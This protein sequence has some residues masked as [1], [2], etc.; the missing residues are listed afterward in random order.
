M[1]ARY[2]THISRLV[3]I[4][5]LFFILSESV[6]AIDLDYIVTIDNPNS[7]QAKVRMEVKNISTEV[8][9]V[10]EYGSVLGYGINVINLIAGDKEGNPLKVDYL[11]SN[12]IGREPG[13][14]DIYL[15]GL[16]QTVIEYTIDTKHTIGYYFEGEPYYSYISEKFAV[17]LAEYLFLFPYFGASIDSITVRFNVPED[18][19]II[20]P[21][22]LEDGVYNP[23]GVKAADIYHQF[24]SSVLGLGHFDIYSKLTNSSNITVA[25]FEDWET[26]H[27][28]ELAEKVWKIYSYQTSIWGNSLEEPYIAIFCP[29]A[30]D[31]KWIYGGTGSTGQ[32]SC[33]GKD[34]YP[35]WSDYAHEVAET[36]WI[37]YDWGYVD[38]SC[39][40]F[41]AGAAQ[42]YGIKTVLKTF[43]EDTKRAEYQL[44]YWY[45]I[46]LQNYL[47]PGKDMILASQEADNEHDIGLCKG[48]PVVLLLAEEIYSKTH[49]EFNFDDLNR[50]LF[51]KYW[52]TGTRVGEE[53]LKKEL[54][55]LT[56]ID[57][58]DFFDYY[59]YG[60]PKLSMDWAYKDN[61]GDGLSNAVEV[62]L[63][64]NPEKED[65]DNHGI[66]DSVE[67]ENK[68]GSIG[69]LERLSYHQSLTGDMTNLEKMRGDISEHFDK[70]KYNFIS[71]YYWQAF[72]LPYNM[73]KTLYKEYYILP[74]D[75][76]LILLQSG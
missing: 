1:S 33:I 26:E 27:K 51:E 57:F 58:S 72:P 11:P 59:I 15:N 29:Y 23:L 28:K 66:K 9:K 44:G 22:P 45:D 42:F 17:F 56:G 74:F 16:S 37:N 68:R 38:N 61:D 34:G 31:G 3:L 75:Y 2:L 52:G 25:I 41:K 4:I 5:A 65:T 43:I 47:L 21:W 8:F 24:G 62:F 36:R 30:N 48:L 14:W 46:Y 55:A 20:T 13:F 40:W 18:W 67:I 71:P 63:G 69:N 12:K 53:E 76:F 49:G 70:V 60:M 6:S 64:S 35:W 10:M 7:G 73:N 19:K 50:L 54:R 39:Y 32:I